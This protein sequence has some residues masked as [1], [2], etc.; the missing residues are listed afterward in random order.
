MLN[1]VG[2]GRLAPELDRS[3]T[4]QQ[5]LS[6]GEQQRLSLARALL[7]RPALLILDEATNQLDEEAALELMALLRREL[8]AAALLFISHQSNLAALGAERFPLANFVPGARPL[9]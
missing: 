9:Q 3:C 2:L 6:G 5:L 7:Q 8:P 4:W 1:L